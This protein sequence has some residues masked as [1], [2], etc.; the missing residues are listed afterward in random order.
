[1]VLTLTDLDNK[2]FELIPFTSPSSCCIYRVP[3][4]LRHINERAY[5]PQVVSIGP[6]H[7][8]K[9]HLKFMEEEKQRYLKEFLARTNI[10]LGEL[11]NLITVDTEDKIR[12]CYSEAI[13][14]DRQKFVEIILVD[15]IFIIEVLLRNTYPTLRN[16]K[17]DHIFKQ[18][19]LLQDIWYDMW[20][21][22]NQLPFFILD[23]F[24]NLNEVAEKIPVE[25]DYPTVIYLTYKFFE[26]LEAV[27]GKLQKLIDCKKEVK[28]FT[29]FLRICHLPS[30]LPSDPPGE[31]KV[32]TAPSVTQ[33]H[34]AGV[35]FE[36]SESKESFDIKF[37]KG[38]LKIPQLK[39]QLETESLF[40]NMIAF[41]QR[42]C[43]DNYI[44]DYVFIIH[45]LV[46]TPKDVELLVQKQIIENWL[47]DKEGV[48]T[49]INNLSRGTTLNP[50]NFYF[51]KLCKDLKEYRETRCNMWRANLKQNYF[52]TPWASISVI[53]AIFLILL[54]VLQAVFSVIQVESQSNN[55]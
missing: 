11:A 4:R 35:R 23:E 36:L 16:E 9:E 8:G 49:L 37:E 7:H 26:D 34:Q 44:N 1:M 24:L 47:P 21:L 10:N 27:N 25:N 19:Y 28:H 50:H 20:L 5:T 32:I 22:E 41:E 43:P 29:D 54:T 51:S 39:L 15:S 13:R 2:L 33:L 31:K 14:M 53:G 38:T 6:F 42:H 46:N 48:S 18:P 12:S 45:H 52:N 55:C 30:Y 3:E 40:R 17:Q